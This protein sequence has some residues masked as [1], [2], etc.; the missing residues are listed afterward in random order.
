MKEVVIK[1]IG[2]LISENNY[3][4]ETPRQGILADDGESFI[5]LNPHCNFEQAVRD[6]EGFDRIWVIYLFH[7][8]PNWRPLVQPPRHSRKKIGVFATRAP[9]RPNPIGISCVR[10]LRIEGLRIYITNSDILNGSPVID[11]KPYL[12]YSDSFPEART[13]WV[14]DGIEEIYS[15]DFSP[16]AERKLS[17]LKQNAGINLSG[18]SKLQLEFN[19]MDDSRKRVKKVE[20]ADP[21]NNYILSYRTWRI[22][23]NVNPAMRTVI[24]SDI[25]SGYSKEDISDNEPDKYGDK[26]LHRRFLSTEF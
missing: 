2:T 14:K 13:G 26:D 20:A 7:L 11:I 8:N 12:P 23:Y 5:Q 10:L 9:Y 16:K 19:P 18:F 17:W 15:V 22:C 24:I 6:L 1:P 25:A 21:E 3:R 4:Y